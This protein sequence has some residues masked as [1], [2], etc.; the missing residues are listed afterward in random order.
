MTIEGKRIVVTRATHQA[1]PLADA[2][3]TRGAIPI[4]YPTIAI[5]PTEDP[6]LRRA[7]LD[8]EDFDWIIITSANTAVALSEY[9]LLLNTVKVAA[10]GETTADAIR[11]YMEEVVDFTP[12]Q[13]TGESLAEHLPDVRSHTRIF[14]PQSAKADNTLADML[15]ARS[16]EVV[17]VTAYHNVVSYEGDADVP[18]MLDDGQVDAFTFT[19]G[20][21]VENLT[22]R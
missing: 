5:K 2:L 16:A 22:A 18:G 9:R 8:S 14:L 20:S 6:A 7:I 15:R 13:Q 3:R 10:V 17:A 12:R 1:E 4:M 21:T 19:S 11:E